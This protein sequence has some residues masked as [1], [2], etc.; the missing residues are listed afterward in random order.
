MEEF[1][2]PEENGEEK[3]GLREDRFV[4]RQHRDN[5]VK[6]SRSQEKHKK[7]ATEYAEQPAESENKERSEKVHSGGNSTVES[8]S[9]GTPKENGNRSRIS[10]DNRETNRG[11]RENRPSERHLHGVLKQKKIL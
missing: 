7:E 6:S 1:L 8:P 5:E 3:S 11:L 2:Q 9:G 10:E 4:Q